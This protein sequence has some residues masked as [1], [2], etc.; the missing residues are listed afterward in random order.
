MSPPSA[1]RC[2]VKCELISGEISA[3]FSEY[4]FEVIIIFRS[5]SAA[6][7]AL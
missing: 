5:R 4:L 3:S 6:G 7:A 1:V 2:S